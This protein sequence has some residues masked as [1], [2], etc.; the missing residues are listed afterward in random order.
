VLNLLKS[1][2][3]ISENKRPAAS[4]T[5]S[6]PNSATAKRDLRYYL[7]IVATVFFSILLVL[8]C[9]GISVSLV[10]FEPINL[11]LARFAHSDRSYEE[12]EAYQNIVVEVLNYV[13]TLPLEAPTAIEVNQDDLNILRQWSFFENELCHLTDVRVLLGWVLL[14]TYIASIFSLL[15]VTFLRDKQFVRHSLLAAGISC[16][17]LPFIGGAFI[18]FF[19]D[20]TFVLFHEIF[21][22]QGNW[23]FPSDTLIISTFP[24]HYWQTAGLLLMAFFMIGGCIL[25]ALSRF[26]GKMYAQSVTNE[27]IHGSI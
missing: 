22:P 23:S 20:A 12:L 18:Y 25:T 7:T 8:T 13:T 24:G 10:A 9:L 4:S 16:L 3:F 6:S 26:C 19:F 2:N 14:L 5:D 1:I 11:E 15:V 27:P 17:A 21:F